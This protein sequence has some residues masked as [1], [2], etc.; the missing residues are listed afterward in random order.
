MR[1]LLGVVGLLLPTALLCLV[2]AA[3]PQLPDGAPALPAGVEP[4][5]RGPIH[6]AFAEPYQGEAKPS[7]IVPKQPPAPLE[8]VPPDEK[9]A[10]AN[11][12]WIPGYWAWDDERADF[13]WVSGFWRD[14]PPHR[15]WMPGYWAQVDNGS[16]WVPGYWADANQTQQELLPPPP[17]SVD[18]G[19]STPAPGAQ[20]SYVPGIWVFRDNRYAWRPGFWMNMQQGWIYNPARYCWTPSGYLFN[21][22]YWDYP[23][24]NRGLLFAPVAINNGAWNQPG[25]A[26]TPSYAIN[27]AS[28]LSAL[29]VRPLMGHYYF[30]NYFGQGYTQAGYVPW[31]NYRS[32]RNVNNPLVSYYGWNNQGNLL[33]EMRQ[34]YTLRHEGRAPLPAAHFREQRANNLAMVAPINRLGKQVTL[35][36]VAPAQLSADRKA[37]ATL[38][39]A[40]SQRRE[41]DTR[42]AGTK[43]DVPRRTA[44][45]PHVAAAAKAPTAP[46]RAEVPA[47]P[48]VPEHVVRPLPPA[49]PP[50]AAHRFEARPTP[51]PAPP[52]ANV[53]QKTAPR[54]TPPPARKVEEKKTAA[55][56]ARIEQK[57]A[58]RVAPPPPRKVEEPRAVPAPVEQKTAPRSAPPPA[59]KVEEKKAAPRPS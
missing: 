55:A 29:F 38:R 26:Y 28:L 50:V 46:R 51:R 43:A 25:W 57:P 16:Q 17:P 36:K 15:V 8:E 5:T 35:H 41:Q 52:P 3:R 54:P 45:L 47:H 21:D 10:G 34:Q 58:P 59:R 53:E 33:T 56:P 6:E 11:V 13:I 44:P 31:I 27:P 20:S 12:S 42:L 1:R 37:A 40:V 14:I 18:D 48:T 49:A 19:P 2:P 23:L 30:G 4:L 39:S 32:G 24:Q 7:P 22:A 9:P